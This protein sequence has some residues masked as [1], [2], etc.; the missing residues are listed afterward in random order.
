MRKNGEYPNIWKSGPD[1]VRHKQ[2]LVWLQQKNQAQYRKEPWALTFE[3]WL[4]MW[5][6]KW[7]QR[8]RGPNQ[9]CMTRL[10]MSKPWDTENTVVME[11]GKQCS[12]SNRITFE[13][14][15]ME[16]SK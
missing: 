16:K 4:D 14:K 9:Y 13:K 12:R 2:Y 7:E 10:D 1:P 8:G 6:D 5:K 3:Q 11:R 15:Q